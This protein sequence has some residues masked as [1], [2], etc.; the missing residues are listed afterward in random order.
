MPN[1]SANGIQI[2][3]DTIGDPTLRPLLLIMGLG[4]QLIH[5]DDGF[6]HLLADLGHYVIRFDHRDSGLSTKFDAA[7]LPDMDEVFNARLRGESIQSPY[8]LDDMADDAAGLLE[9]INI[10]KAHI[11]GASMGG[12][13]AQILAVRHPQRLLSLISIYSSTG[14]P[15]LPQPQPQAMEALMTPQPA[16]RQAYI[17]FNVKTH[18]VISGTG[19]PFD[20]AFIRDISAKSFDRAHYPPGV[21]RQ[22]LA[23]MAAKNRK[24]DLAAITAPTLVVHG[25]ADP[26]VPF[27]HGQATADAIS[28]AQLFPV[29]GMGHDLP[30]RDGP[31]PR[32]IDAIAAHTKRAETDA[33]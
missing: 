1:V 23:V 30:R 31:W 18:H 11:C 13:I 32:V 16:E 10:P 25:T 33:E 14:D 15:D 6:C 2:E 21:G 12:M 4:G 22:M 19:F 7:G 28:G 17:E 8:T 5:W 27:A 9:A 3:Y 20:E 24:S 29:E 26:V